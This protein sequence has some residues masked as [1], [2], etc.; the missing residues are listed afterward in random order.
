MSEGGCTF[1]KQ[2]S[3]LIFVLIRHPEPE[4][5]DALYITGAAVVI[6]VTSYTISRLKN[7]VSLQ[8]TSGVI[9]LLFSLHFLVQIE[10][11]IQVKT[12]V[13]MLSGWNF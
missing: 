10:I 4:N 7:H 9:E 11:R 3:S 2:H 5:N 8:V 12:L 6:T 1:Y 13:I